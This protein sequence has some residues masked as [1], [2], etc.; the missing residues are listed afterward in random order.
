MVDFVNNQDY[1]TQG[2]HCGGKRRFGET[3]NM[4]SLIDS[5]LPGTKEYFN[6]M[7]L[8]FLPKL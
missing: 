7:T 4:H 1:G 2:R 3:A 8:T 5:W 6:E